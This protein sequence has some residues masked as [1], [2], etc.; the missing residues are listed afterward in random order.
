MGFATDGSTNSM[1]HAL[2][3]RLKQRP[4]SAFA[5]QGNLRG[6][7]TYGG[8]L[9]APSAAAAGDSFAAA[10]MAPSASAPA[11][12]P[13]SSYVITTDGSLRLHGKVVDRTE[14]SALM[15]GRRRT[16]APPHLLATAQH[17]AAVA[18]RQKH[19]P[20]TSAKLAV[21]LPPPPAAATP[22]VSE[23]PEE[24]HVYDM[25]ESRQP[26]LLGP[27][28]PN[29]D[30]GR[31]YRIF[32]ST[33][34]S[35]RSEVKHLARTVERMLEAAGPR[36]GEA[37]QA[38]DIALSELVRQVFVGCAEQRLTL[39][40]QYMQC[41]QCTYMC[42]CS[43]TCSCTCMRYRCGAWRASRPRAPRLPALHPGAG[44][45]SD[46]Y[47]VDSARDGSAQSRG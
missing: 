45:E 13:S 40:M 7:A 14:V 28:V 30:Q 31:R 8:V 10:D 18:P 15:D 34:P 4:L 19:V 20:R 29:P 23:I 43:C 3:E 47:G 17:L 16:S 11:M 36:T 24:Y 37:L 27:D 44:G 42:T 5:S 12:R 25:L 41:I 46:F 38:W 6:S 32:P 33:R 39:C 9:I 35:N 22:P 21:D 2:Q 26:V 1:Q